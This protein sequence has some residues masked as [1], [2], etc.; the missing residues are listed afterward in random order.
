M[1]R[2]RLAA[3][4]PI[5]TA[6]IIWLMAG[7]ALA[8]GVSD[9]VEVIV[10]QSDASPH[11]RM[12]VRG[13]FNLVKR[14]A[15][16]LTAY[17]LPLTKCEKWTLPKDQLEAVKKAAAKQGL[18]VTELGAGWDHVFQ[19]TPPDLA[20]SAKQK[21]LLDLAKRGKATTDARIMAGPSPSML[22]YALTKDAKAPAGG[23]APKLTVAL[24]DQTVLTIARTSLD[25]KRNLFIWRG[26]VEQ[27][28]GLVTLMWWPNGKMAGTVQDQGKIYSIRHMGGHYYAVVELNT[29]RMPREHAA[30]SASVRASDPNLRDDP[31]VQQGDASLLRRLVTAMR[32]PPAP[33]APPQDVPR[34]RAAAVAPKSAAPKSAASSKDVVIDVMVA[35]TRKAASNYGDV[36][37]ELVD[38]A[39]EEGNHSLRISNLG[40]IKLRLVHA[41]Q[42]SYV[43]EGEHFQHL[44]RFADRGDSYMDEIH[45]LR[46]KHRADVAVL[47][48]DDPAGCGLST[49][50]YAEAEEAYSVVHHECAAASYSLAHEIGHLI[51]ARHEL[52]LDKN[53]TPFPY[54]HG[55][56]NGSKWRDIMSHKVSCGGC[57][58]MPVWSSPN[59]RVKGDPAGSPDLDNRRVIAEQAA[60]VAAFR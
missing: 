38:L 51:G 21:A 10:S 2:A 57:P 50:V 37:R 4:V 7:S 16:S 40:H 56:V 20:I 6:L 22:E 23:E 12:S 46:D 24:S 60:R 27:T 43:E 15:A 28:G 32:Q 1:I 42:T 36:K 25:L 45:S 31:L 47:I 26:E 9:S 41:Y 52:A 30:L 8:Q 33:A 34:K 29:E 3:H 17:A 18:L 11:S 35:F 53:M 13:F 48:V 49:R 44:W 5:L 39:I 58:R 14:T 55:F 19:A 59:V 54:G